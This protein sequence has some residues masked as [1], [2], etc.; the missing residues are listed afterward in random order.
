MTPLERLSTAQRHVTLQVLRKSLCFAL[1]CVED[2]V[3]NL[4]DDEW[5]AYSR[6]HFS[7]APHADALGFGCGRVAVDLGRGL[8]LK[9]PIAPEGLH[10]S[11][12]ESAYW[13]YSLDSQQP[14]KYLLP[15]YG[16]ICDWAL[17]QPAALFDCKQEQSE[18]WAEHVAGLLATSVEDL[19]DH[20]A[21]IATYNGNVVLAD[22]E[23]F[24]EAQVRRLRLKRAWEH[25]AEQATE[26]LVSLHKRGLW[27]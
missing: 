19:D 17:L 11:R 3:W 14:E 26:L 23:C 22:Y 12:R 20:T 6:E 7:L 18:A 15:Q 8:V 16:L 5:E 10:G 25:H 21:N 24:S 13:Y 2:E 1:L 4:T 9:V 27:D